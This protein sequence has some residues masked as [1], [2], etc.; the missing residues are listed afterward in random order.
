M[1]REGRKWKVR[2]GEGRGRIKVGRE[3]SLRRVWSVVSNI[4]EKIKTMKYRKG[5]GGRM[6]EGERPSS[7]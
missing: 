7:H 4:G 1:R 6:G 5:R 2:G 3:A